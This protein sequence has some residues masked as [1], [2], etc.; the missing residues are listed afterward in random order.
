MRMIP[1][2][3]PASAWLQLSASLRR[4]RKKRT[5]RKQLLCLKRQDLNVVSVEAGRWRHHLQ[6]NHKNQNNT[7]SLLYL[8][9]GMFHMNGNCDWSWGGTDWQ[10][11][12]LCPSPSP[13]CWLTGWAASSVRCTFHG[14]SNQ[15]HAALQIFSTC[16]QSWGME[17]HMETLCL[18]EYWLVHTL[19]QPIQMAVVMKIIKY[20]QKTV[21]E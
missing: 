18:H 9:Y 19:V 14:H 15:A 3:R 1:E 17:Q 11:R 2:G 6:L 8:P 7:V 5:K 4:V 20:T 21:L 12:Q 10:S 13:P 16:C